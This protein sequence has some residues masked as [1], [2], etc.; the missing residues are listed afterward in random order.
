MSAE[1]D[2]ELD[3]LL[4]KLD[5]WTSR[6]RWIQHWLFDR[7]PAVGWVLLPHSEAEREQ[8]RLH[9]AELLVRKHY[10]LRTGSI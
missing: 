9:E 4:M 6:P 1:E 7:I 8:E 2:D 3:Q 10:I 5:H